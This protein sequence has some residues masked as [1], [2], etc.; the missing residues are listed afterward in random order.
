MRAVPIRIP[1][2]NR[3]RFCTSHTQCVTFVTVTKR[4]EFEFVTWVTRCG[5]FVVFLAKQ[6]WSQI[7][8]M[9]TN[10]NVNGTNLFLSL[11]RLKWFGVNEIR[12][13]I[14][15]SELCFCFL[16]GIRIGTALSICVR[17]CVCVFD[18]RVRAQ[19]TF[20]QV[21]GRSSP[22]CCRYTARCRHPIVLHTYIYR[23]GGVCVS[24]CISLYIPS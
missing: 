11:F 2:R 14:P 19:A 6:I 13:N 12:Q 16:F 5:S 7:S 4:H 3:N 21:P 9:V 23:Y 17:A 10:S 15:E 8:Q 20:R 18:L 24:M 22:K 1:N